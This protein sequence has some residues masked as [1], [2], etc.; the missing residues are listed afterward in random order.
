MPSTCRE[1]LCYTTGAVT[2]LSFSIRPLSGLTGNAFRGLLAK[3]RHVSR[4][5]ARTRPS[6]ATTEDCLFATKDPPRDLLGACLLEPF[7]LFKRFMHVCLVTLCLQLSF[8]LDRLVPLLHA[9]DA[10]RQGRFSTFSVSCYLIASQQCETSASFPQSLH[11]S[12]LQRSVPYCLAYF[13][14]EKHSLAGPFSVQ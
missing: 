11:E 2:D 10:C 13:L 6:I 1:I 9:G 7:G 8:S 14:Q 4:S 3:V 12:F 5:M